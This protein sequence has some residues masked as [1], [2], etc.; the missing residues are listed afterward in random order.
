MAARSPSPLLQGASTH[1]GAVPYFTSS[2]ERPE[3]GEVSRPCGQHALEGTKASEDRALAPETH[4]RGDPVQGDCSVPS[5]LDMFSSAI[6][7][8]IPTWGLRK[9]TDSIR[10]A[11]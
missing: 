11:L 9:S 5:P 3:R 1:P 6:S 10:N 8:V 4:S 2:K 7:W